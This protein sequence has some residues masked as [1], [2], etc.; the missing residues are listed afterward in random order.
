MSN[1]ELKRDHNA[2]VHMFVSGNPAHGAKFTG[3]QLVDGETMAFFVVPLKHATM[4]E[5]GNVVPLVRP[6]G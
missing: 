3:M 6:P 2:Q 4:G 5:M 1:I